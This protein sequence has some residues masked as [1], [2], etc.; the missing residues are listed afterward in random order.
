MR[1]R[2][3]AGEGR[4]RT[5]ESSL[6]DSDGAIQSVGTPRRTAAG[7]PTHAALR[8]S[9]PLAP[10]RQTV[11]SP[12]TPSSPTDP[13]IIPHPP[14]RSQR[15]G[16]FVCSVHGRAPGSPLQ[17]R[18]VAVSITPLSFRDSVDYISESLLD[19]RPRT[20]Y[21]S[22]PQRQTP[23]PCLCRRGLLPLPRHRRRRRRRRRVKASTTEWPATARA[24][25]RVHG[26]PQRAHQA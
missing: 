11:D 16:C 8:A 15:L 10:R 20:R 26:Y 2:E 23:R 1:P 21:S 5:S 22:P 17:V 24:G 9:R 4:R 3:G 13:R 12:Q 6:T 18:N 19:A 14:L 25:P 7:H